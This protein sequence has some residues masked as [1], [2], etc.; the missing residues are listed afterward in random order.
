[1]T[2]KILYFLCTHNSARSQIAE[3]LAKKYL[4]DDYEIYSA[5]IEV[6]QVNPNAI[7]VMADIGIDIS[8][9][10]SKLINLELYLKADIVITLCKD[11]YERCPTVPRRA[12][13]LHWGLNDPAA[14]KGSEQEVL[15][16]FEKTRSELEILMKEFAEHGL[17]GTTPFIDQEHDFYPQKE[18]FAEIMQEIRQEHELSQD[19]LAARLEVNLDFIKRVEE[20]KANPSKFFVHRLASRLNEDYD[21]ILHRLYDVD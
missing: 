16:A 2:K 9:Q 4:S 19:V 1:M 21:T 17:V 11:A 10:A 3:G 5:G 14:V 7:Q 13:H 20:N 6:S 15:E 18:N 8:D 12:K